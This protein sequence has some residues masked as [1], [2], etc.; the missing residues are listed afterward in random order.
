MPP[1]KI[2]KIRKIAPAQ[3]QPTYVHQPVNHNTTHLQSHSESGYLPQLLMDIIYEDLLGG[4]KV[5]SESNVG[6]EAFFQAHFWPLLLNRAQ[7]LSFT[8]LMYRKVRFRLTSHLAIMRLLMSK[9][10]RLDKITHIVLDYGPDWHN[11]GRSGFLF[12]LLFGALA[13]LRTLAV[14]ELEGKWKTNHPKPGR[15]IAQKDFAQA[16]ITDTEQRL[17]NSMELNGVDRS[18]QGYPFI[19]GYKFLSGLTI[20]DHRTCRMVASSII[21]NFDGRETDFNPFRP[22][23]AWPSL[24]SAIATEKMT[25][26]NIDTRLELISWSASAEFDRHPLSVVRKGTPVQDM[27]HRL[28]RLPSSPISDPLRYYDLALAMY[29]KVFEEDDGPEAEGHL[30]LCHEI[31]DSL[32]FNHMPEPVTTRPLTWFYDTICIAKFGSSR[33]D[34]AQLN[35]S[36]AYR[37]WSAYY[38]REIQAEYKAS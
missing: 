15:S 1:R 28:V 18:P 7:Y 13:G 24:L 31:F 8:E 20:R 23:A 36:Q 19:R 32:R 22:A 37:L 12:R 4:L 6:N 38:P 27:C 33:Y 5:K 16:V 10:A 26:Y 30:R 21:L 14:V 9:Y 17:V 25:T 3:S 11:D 34:T 2:R 29:R 35:R